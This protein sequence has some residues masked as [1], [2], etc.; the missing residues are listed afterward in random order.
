M[1]STSSTH[2]RLPIWSG[3][4]RRWRRSA[5]S[6]RGAP[7]DLP[8]TPDARTLENGANFTFDTEWGSFDILADAAGMRDYEAMRADAR[9]DTIEG[10]RGS[11]RLPRRPDRDEASCQPAQGQ[12]DGRGVHRPRRRAEE[13]AQEEEERGGLGRLAR[14]G[15]RQRRRPA[16]PRNLDR[17][18]GVQGLAA[19]FADA[20]LADVAAAD[21]VADQFRRAA[22][23]GG[24]AVA[25]V[26]QG[27]QGR[28]EVEPLLGQ[29]VLVAGGALLVLAA[30][31]DVLVERGAAAAPRA[32]CGRPRASSG[33]RR[34]GGCR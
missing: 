31:E 27:D 13:A 1:T 34:S 25:P 23:G 16:R 11:H 10:V 5:S 4:P 8:F 26:E 2:V 30:L 33:S 7:A 17:V 6:L 21:L 28:P 9:L 18:A 32:R 3:W 15:R 19:L 22:G 12:A 24:V 20:A 14:A 29:E